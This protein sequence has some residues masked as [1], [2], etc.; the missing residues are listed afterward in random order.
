MKNI[1]S[2]GLKL[3]VIL[4]LSSCFKDLGNYSYKDINE[5][6]IGDLGGPY[7]LLFKADT[8][9][10]APEI[11]LTM[12]D[13]DPDRYSYEWRIGF[14]GEGATR[15]TISTE[16]NLVYHVNLQP[17]S[18]T[19]YFNVYD[20]LTEVT[21]TKTTSFSVSSAMDRGFHIAGE[22]EEGFADAD[23]VV[24]V[25]GRDTIIAKSLMKGNGM[26]RYK[27]AIKLMH[28]GGASN[29]NKVKQW[30][31]T[32]EGGYYMNTATMEVKPSNRFKNLIYTTFDL[33]L[34]IFPVA[35]APTVSAASGTGGSGS[36]RM[37]IT[38]TGDLFGGGLNSGDFYANP[39]NRLSINSEELFKLSPYFMYGAT[40]WDRFI[41]FDESNSRFLYA[42]A[43]SS[44]AAS[45]RE[46]VDFG[47]P[48]PWNQ[49]DNGRKLI[50]AE[51][52]KN[53]EDGSTNGNSY[54]LLKDNSNEFHIYKFYVNAVTPVK[55]GYFKIKPVAV[56]FEKASFYAFSSVRKILYY[57]VGSKLY[58][59][60]YNLNFEKNYLIKDF[61]EEITMLNSDI[62][63]SN[64]S[65]LYVATYSLANKGTIVKF[66]TGMDLNNLVMTQDESV[67]WTGLVKVK[68]M[69]WRNSTQ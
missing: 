30:F 18:Y 45:L 8:L 36:T 54:A 20:K 40:R 46:F 31:M 62:Q 3:A 56:D 4:I 50:Y 35:I 21:W 59:Y 24:M 17:K 37:V 34:D 69:S 13:G 49:G 22:D 25:A 63:V 1:C 2:A 44:P 55:L 65:Q 16:R 7:D 15:E 14:T 67:K 33:P 27:G 6:A 52:T 66:D 41:V 48:F 23:M 28:T 64:G 9:K 47:G 43:G 12:D 26:P 29:D 38:N 53:Y 61:G 42:A 19:L 60:D 68:S 11:N 32:N 57:A 58:G 5:I 51:N 10:I 39:V